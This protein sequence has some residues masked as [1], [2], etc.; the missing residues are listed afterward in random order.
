MALTRVGVD[1]V[2]PFETLFGPPTAVT[3]GDQLQGDRSDVTYCLAA[4]GC[5]IRLTFAPVIASTLRT[6]CSNCSPRLRAVERR[7]LGNE[8]A[9][10]AI[11]E[12]PEYHK[13]VNCTGLIQPDIPC[14]RTIG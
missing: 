4:M 2:C 12:R 7:Y 10:A 8:H 1:E 11:A 5:P 9:G 14:I 6:C 13:I 3:E